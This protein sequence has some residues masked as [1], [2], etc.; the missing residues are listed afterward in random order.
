MRARK[1]PLRRTVV[2]AALA[3][4]TLGGALPGSIVTTPAAPSAIEVGAA[5]GAPA[6]AVVPD[7]DT[8]SISERGGLTSTTVNGAISA[9]Y[10]TGAQA[11]YGRGFQ[12]GMRRLTR[13][14]SVVQQSTGPGWGFPMAVTALPTDAIRAVMGR[15]VAGPI[16]AG[17]L[18]MGATTA[19]MRGAAAGD[20]AEFITP[21]GGAA[22]FTIGA[23][24]PDDVIGGTEIVMGI[25]V[26]TS[27]GMTTNTRVLIYGSFDRLQLDLLLFD[28][29]LIL[30]PRVQAWHSWDVTGPDAVMSMLQTKVNFGEFDLNYAGI[31]PYGWT[32]TNYTWATTHLPASREAYP[33]GIVARCHNVIRDDLRAA[34]AE[35]AATYPGLVN[36]NPNSDSQST[37][38]DIANTNTYGGCTPAVTG[39]GGRARLSRNGIASGIVS[40]HSWGV[41]LDTSTAANCQGCVPVMDCRIVWIF[42]KHNF[43]WGGT[44]LTPDGMHFEWV[45]EPRH[46]NTKPMP[47]CS[48]P[49]PSATSQGAGPPDGA[50]GTSIRDVMFGDDGWALAE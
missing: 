17:Q 15:V 32:D 4:S 34:L 44:F 11:V 43:A 29:G 40:R 22:T 31:S 10:R 14:T 33:T 16:A 39:G 30:N 21:A 1:A 25:D 46:L 13:G 28:A 42:R 23:I 48:N 5:G 18:V 9:A 50:M 20:R 26:A 7:I 49:A 41:A 8:I 27:I 38:L 2:G 36:S 35:V 12:L 45:G 3:V 6:V 24:V 19:A 37:G 47:Y